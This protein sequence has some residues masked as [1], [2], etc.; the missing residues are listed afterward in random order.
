MEK[1]VNQFDLEWK[2]HGETSSTNL[3]ISEERA[4]LLFIIDTYNKHLIEID[5]KPVR[6]VREILDDFAKEL[7]QQNNP[8]I[9]KILFKFRQFFSNYRID[10]YTYLQKTFSE[11]R[12]IIWDF[13]DQLGE[14]LDEEVN[15]ELEINESLERL[16]EAVESDSIDLLKSQSREFI[17]NYIELQTR[18]DIKRSDK[19]KQIKKNLYTVKEK[20]IAANHNMRLDH[21]TSAF[22]R[23]SFDEQM[24]QHWKLFQ[25]SK[26]AVSLIMLDIDHFKRIND[27]FGHSI[28]DFALKEL[29]KI[30]HDNFTRDND[31]VARIGGEEFA[32]ILP[33][34]KL[35]GA[36]QMAEKLRKRVEH[37]V[38]VQDDMELNFT[39]SMGIAQL[40]VKESIEEWMKRA[41]QAL[42]ES[43]NNGR[44]KFTLASKEIQDDKAAS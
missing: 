17:D 29:V 11:F 30:L 5:T 40:Q 41:D 2:P 8:N 20:L 32:I 21:L 22:N 38:F 15:E 36:A 26:E 6:K 4:T 23:K 35:M 27:V 18:R 7:V 3:Q 9:E 16:K 12:S 37:E 33:N 25:H 34:Y 19:E 28:G 42:Y 10:E 39:V 43:K 14:E 31:F 44:N 1:L 24:I 13:V